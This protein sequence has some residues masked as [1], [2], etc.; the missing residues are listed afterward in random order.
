MN[1]NIIVKDNFFLDPNYY[2]SLALSKKDLFRSPTYP[3]E[4]WKGYRLHFKIEKD[5][6][7]ILNCVKKSFLLKTNN[8]SLETYFH[9]TLEETKKTC[10]PTFDDYKIHTDPYAYAGIVYLTPN[11]NIKTGTTFINEN[12]NSKIE[13]YNIYNRL[14]CY[15]GNIL[16]GPTDLFG[17]DIYNGRLTLTFFIS[18]I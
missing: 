1:N 11:A 14:I 9:Y 10:F 3:N 12:N 16:H 13:I 2:R 7:C 18:L 5:T 17:D 6:D 4:T 8:F 15:P